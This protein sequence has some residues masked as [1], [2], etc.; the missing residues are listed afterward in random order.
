MEVLTLA[1]GLAAGYMLA[2]NQ[3]KQDLNRKGASVFV[4]GC[5]DPRFSDNLA[6]FLTHNEKLHDNYD[7]FCLAGASL[8]VVQTD[9]PAWGQTFIDHLNLAIQLHDIKEVW[10]FDHFDCGFYKAHFQQETDKTPGLHLSSMM[11]LQAMLAE[12]HPNLGF[13]GYI[14]N[15]DGKIAQHI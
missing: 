1:G 4:L 2:Q 3:P 10:V 5:F 6:W 11:E 7:L 9:I 12:S 8:G 13:K 15:L 14:I